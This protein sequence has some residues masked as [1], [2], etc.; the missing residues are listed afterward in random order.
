MN[1]PK[2]V[3]STRIVQS[4][5]PGSLGSAYRVTVKAAD[6]DKYTSSAQRTE[7]GQGQGRSTYVLDDGVDRKMYQGQERWIAI[8]LLIP[9]S[10]VS[11]GWNSFTQ[12]KGQG[13]G[14]GPFGL[15]FGAGKLILSKSRTQAYGSIT[16][17]DVWVPPTPTTRDQWL[18]VLMHV[19]WST[20]SDGFYE[21]FG[22]L[23]DGHGFQRLKPLTPG[24]TLKQGSDGKP[25]VVGI[26]SG[27]YRQAVAKDSSIFFDSVVVAASR[28]SATYGAFGAVR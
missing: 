1:D 23:K 14:N 21:L 28:D 4:T 6:R 2:W 18:E 5:A 11:G 12:F 7:L 3:T 16:L 20:G 24:W 19:K 25:V 17:A 13:S 10:Y 8:R 9:A 15:Y 26:R 27:I 22:D